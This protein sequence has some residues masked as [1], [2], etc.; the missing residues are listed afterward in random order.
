MATDTVPAAAPGSPEPTASTTTHNDPSKGFLAA[1]LAPVEPARPTFDLSPDTGTTATPATPDDALDRSAPGMSSASF[2]DAEQAAAK[3]ATGE[4]RKAQGSI[5]KAWFLAGATRWAKGGGAANKRF[6]MKK[7]KAQAHQVK[8]NRTTSVMNSGG[9]SGRNSVG[10][11]GASKGNSGKAGG[12]SRGKG[13]P[14]SARSGSTGSNGS[15]RGGSGGGR[16]TAGGSGPTGS[17][18]AGGGKNGKNDTRGT[19][20]GPNGSTSNEKGAA[21]TSGS[22]GTGGSGKNADADGKNSSGGKNGKPKGSGAA[23]P[24]DTTSGSAAPSGKSGS[25]GKDGKPGKPGTSGN[26]KASGRPDTRTPLQKSREV[27]H[28][29]G[30]AVRNVIDHVKAYKDGT[31]DGY[32]DKNAENAKEH[33]RL[34]KAHADHKKKTDKAQK[35]DPAKAGSPTEQEDDGVSTDIKP[36][37]I[38]NID[39]NTLTLGTDGAKSTVSRKELRNFKQY[40]RKLE[41]KETVLQNIADACKQ[42]EKQAEDEAKDCQDLVE[43]AKSVEGG[44]KVIATLNRLAETAKSQAVEA[45]ELAQRARRSAEMCKAV[46][47]NIQTRY[48]PLYKAVVESGETKPGE[49]RFYNDKGSYTPAA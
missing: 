9:L 30:G 25:A 47:T 13:S 33:D 11:G 43:Q 20:P 22:G 15:D 48:A 17:N 41:V 45:A 5:W 2:R 4:K 6:D 31:V 3:D 40:E 18:G 38:K 42:L 14:N 12:D 16:G 39:A 36:L 29:D 46:L 27:G 37:T 49:L 32:R 23:G 34:D 21:G 28:K 7:A 26:D 10:A 19:S 35:T 44:E 8:E 24:S 1:M